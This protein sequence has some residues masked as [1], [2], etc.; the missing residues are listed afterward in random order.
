MAD[1]VGMIRRYH[2]GRKLPM[3][4]PADEMRRDFCYWEGEEVRMLLT[5]LLA[6]VQSTQSAAL[7][8]PAA[9]IRA[10]A[11]VQARTEKC[12]AAVMH[13]AQDKASARARRLI[14]LPPGR[15]ELTVMRMIDGC[16]IPAVVREGIGAN[17][18]TPGAPEGRER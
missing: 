17:P 16:P 18:V 15:L 12:R 8:A 11:P 1:A 4:P 3:A 2:E 13:H 6:A 14:E 5:I 9:D 10:F 7:P